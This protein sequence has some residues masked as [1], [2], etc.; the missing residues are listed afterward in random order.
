MPV[1]SKTQYVTVTAANT[2]L[3]RVLRKLPLPEVPETELVIVV[4]SLELEGALGGQRCGPRRFAERGG[5]RLRSRFPE[6]WW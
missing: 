3:N 4:E 2:R 6:L 1:V 5:D